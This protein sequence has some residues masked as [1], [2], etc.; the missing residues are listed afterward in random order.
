M[1]S[2]SFR[3]LVATDGSEDARAAIATA[4]S[5]PWPART[6][7]RI[8]AARRTRAAYRRSILLSALDRGADAAA[9]TARRS[10][11]R[12]WPDVDVVVVDKVPV[13]G[14]LDEAGKFSADVIVIGWRGHGAF[15]RLLMGSVSRA[16]VRGATCSVLVVGRRVRVRRIVVGLD[17]SAMA[18]RALAVLEGLLPPPDGRVV[19]HTVVEV[20]AVP[21]H[22]AVPRAADVSREVK[23]INTKRAKAAAKELNRAAARLTRAGWHT[24]TVLTSGEPLR[25]LLTTVAGTRSQLLV[26]GARGASGVRQLLL[27]SVAEGALTRS[28]VPVLIAR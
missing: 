20:M 13:K 2:K 10:L 15:R 28:S 24:R 3:V 25:D 11:S 9:E 23:R 17:G 7:V 12:R 21:S 1:S 26:V 6:Q 16:V 4:I 27:G 8:V 22:V 14:I 5:I 19:L 18:R